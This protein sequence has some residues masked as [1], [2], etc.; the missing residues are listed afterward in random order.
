MRDEIIHQLKDSSAKREST[1]DNESSEILSLEKEKLEKELSYY[2]T[3]LFTSWFL[4]FNIIIFTF[5]KDGTQSMGL[6][7]L[8]MILLYFIA[9][10]NNLKGFKNLINDIRKFNPNRNKNNKK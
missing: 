9:Y 4:F 1:K 2:K 3:L 7:I 5:I 10:H 8:E 6:L